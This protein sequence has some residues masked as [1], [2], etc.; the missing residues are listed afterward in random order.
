MSYLAWNIVNW[1]RYLIFFVW[2]VYDGG[3]FRWYFWWRVA[4]LLEWSRRIYGL[5]IRE[6][7]SADQES[8]ITGGKEYL[9]VVFFSGYVLAIA[10]ITFSH[11]KIYQVS[12]ISVTTLA[13]G[14][15]YLLL[16]RRKLFWKGI[17]NLHY[18]KGQLLQKHLT[19]LDYRPRRPF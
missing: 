10:V 3:H 19:N 13:R 1:R 9:G 18:T 11:Y 16:T 12:K 17:T 6:T 4:P 2:K 15:A 8:P 14:A 7:C 5:G